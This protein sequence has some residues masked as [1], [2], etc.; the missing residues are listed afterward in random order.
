MVQTARPGQVQGGLHR[1]EDLVDDVVFGKV[2]DQKVVFRLLKYLWRYKFLTAVAAVATFLFTLTTLVTPYLL[3]YAIDGPIAHGNLTGVDF[4]NPSL[5]LIFLVFVASGLLGWLTT[6]LRIIC[7]AY[8]GQGVFYT[9]RTQMFNHL[10]KLSLSFYDRHEVGRIMSRV[11]G[12]VAALQE[13]FTNGAIEVVVAIL[14]MIGVA[15]ILFIMNAELTLIALTVMPVLFVVMGVWQ[16]FARSSFMKVRQAA[17][18]V[19]AELQEN[20]SGAK[21]IQSLSREDESY[22]GFDT[23]NLNNLGANL[24]AIRYSAGIFPVSG[25]LM[26][27]S[28]LLI[29]IIGGSAV[30]A[31]E[32][33]IGE[34]I[35]FLLYMGLFFEPIIRLTMQYTQVQRAMAGGQRIF[36]VLDTEPEIKDAEGAVELPPVRGDIEFDHVHH[37]YIPGLEVLHDI[38][39]KVNAGETVALVGATG[40]GKSTMVNLVG[41]FYE[42]TKGTLRVDGY[43]ISQV[44]QESLRRQISIVLQDPFIFSGTVRENVLYGR[45]GATEEDMISAATA[46]GAHDFI[47]RLPNGYDTELQQSGS[48]LSLGQRQLIS[49]SRAILADPRIL[50]LD[51]ATANVDTQTEITIQRA[52]RLLL[53]DRTSLIIA[54]RL[55][56]IREAN[57][58]VVL[59][60]GYIVETGTHEE[61]MAKDGIYHNLYTMSYTYGDSA[62][63]EMDTDAE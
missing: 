42:L 47:M 15:T 3:G 12:D 23:V 61:L 48:N 32:M 52:L 27:I 58:V 29:I 21:V 36:E 33:Q 30:L 51:E 7:M 62:Q 10:Q 40:S 20:I 43:D 24:Q 16:R 46:V 45:A 41:R 56:T 31:G 49:F 44:T 25:L 34:F 18:L 63:S 38:S 6:Y 39:L 60:D 54:H 17:S 19:N 57:R 28:R 22:R 35:S 53:K 4:S 1:A 37:E 59:K 14:T 5:F 9:L 55:S 11:G 13:V 8:V 2:Y 26:S 50:I